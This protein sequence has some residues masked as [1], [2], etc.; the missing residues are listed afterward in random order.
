MNNK[1]N[2]II[3]FFLLLTAIFTSCNTFQ[4]LLKKNEVQNDTIV[5]RQGI[6]LYDA[7]NRFIVVLDSVLSDSRCPKGVV[8]VW[9]GNAEVQLRTIMTLYNKKQYFRLNTNPQFTQDTVINNYRFKLLEINPY[10]ENEKTFPHYNYRATIV[11][12]KQ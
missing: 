10:P 3:I 8:C 1:R 11:I 4:D 2:S 5:L 12:E 9:E 7:T 6:P